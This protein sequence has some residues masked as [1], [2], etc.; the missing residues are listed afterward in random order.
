[1]R[2]KSEKNKDLIIAVALAL[3]VVLLTGLVLDCSHDWG[4]DFAAYLLEGISLSKGTYQKQISLNYALHSRLDPRIDYGK[5]RI[6]VWGYPLLLS[7]VHNIVGY[8]TAAFNS[9]VY[10]KIPGLIF[11][12]IFVFVFYLFL[13]RRFSIPVSA[14]LVILFC[15]CTQVTK[16]T[17]S[18]T[19]EIVFLSMCFASFYVSEKF[20]EQ[21]E[22]KRI[23]AYGILLGIC[24]WYTYAV[25]LNGVMILLCVLF[26]QIL[27][28]FF[29]RKKPFSGDDLLLLLPY[30]V[31][32]LLYLVF[33]IFVLGKATSQ[34]SDLASSSF[35]TIVSN[36]KAYYF[37]VYDWLHDMVLHLHG[38]EDSFSGKIVTAIILMIES[39][40]LVGIVSNG[41]KKQNVHLTAFF[42]S[43]FVGTCLLP[44]AKDQKIRYIF[45]LLPLFMMYVFYGI[46][47]II[48]LIIGKRRTET[49][50]AKK[51]GIIKAVCCICFALYAV[52]PLTDNAVRHGANWKNHGSG[53]FSD[54]SCEAYSYIQNNLPQD[55][56]IMVSQYRAVLLNTNRLTIRTE[57]DINTADYYMHIENWERFPGFS[58]DNFLE[59]FHNDTIHLYKLLK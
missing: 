4:D 25:R 9:L 33:N 57:G 52:F 16:Y 28:R 23:I 15:T 13:R 1:M 49:V 47:K 31:F 6:Y 27:S 29:F 43:C 37:Y 36:V 35:S 22:N 41:F 51:A 59:I 38:S 7:L 24:L 26:Q 17:N 21:Q 20:L 44:Y 3:I 46:Q 53:A 50:P 18:T 45:V 48:T 40:F 14:L 8:D 55:C 10:Y 30:A 2:R 11:L 34:T 54:D 42:I 56:V 12:G 39:L 32:G 19:T 58:K 5:T